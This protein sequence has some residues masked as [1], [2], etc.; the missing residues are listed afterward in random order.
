MNYLLRCAAF[1][2]LFSVGNAQSV[3]QRRKKDAVVSLVAGESSGYDGGAIAL[4]QSLKDVGSKLHR[5]LLVDPE[6]R[7]L[8]NRDDCC[9]AELSAL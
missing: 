2:V 9:V 4:G 7:C 6:V 8:Q 5:V 1:L 3:N